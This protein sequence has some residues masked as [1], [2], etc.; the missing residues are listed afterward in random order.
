MA[1]PTRAHGP[2]APRDAHMATVIQQREGIVESHTLYGSPSG[3]SAHAIAKRKNL[4]KMLAKRM[5]Q[6]H[7]A[8]AVRVAL[9]QGELDTFKPLQRGDALTPRDLALLESNVKRAVQAV[10]SDCRDIMPAERWPRP[11][12]GGRDG[13]RDFARDLSH[14]ADWTTVSKHKMGYYQGA[15]QRE[16]AERT[17]KQ[18]ELSSYLAHMAAEEKARIRHKELAIA[19]EA[20]ALVVLESSYKAELHA[21]AAKKHAKTRKFALSVDSQVEASPEPKPPPRLATT[22][23]LAS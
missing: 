11:K 9:I 20:K 23:T 21:A 1:T 22:L 4:T 8:D 12:Q 7:G 19:E 16:V 2:G 13:G 6:E 18:A 15:L 17:R 3:Q 5:Q 10:G 14:V